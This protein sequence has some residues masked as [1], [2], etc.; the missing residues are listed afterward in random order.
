MLSDHARINRKLFRVKRL[1]E[2]FWLA[3][4]WFVALPDMWFLIDFTSPVT[5]L[6]RIS[7]KNIT[8]EGRAEHPKETGLVILIDS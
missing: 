4:S 6:I 2:T 5:A 7:L 8:S 3:K 1:A